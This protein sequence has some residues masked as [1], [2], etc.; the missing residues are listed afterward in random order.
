M[1]VVVKNIISRFPSRDTLVLINNKLQ[2]VETIKTSTTVSTVTPGTTTT[3][4]LP[5]N[6]VVPPQSTS[7]A[8]QGAG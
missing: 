8:N 6:V 3:T 7:T 2:S 4:V 1:A 5:T